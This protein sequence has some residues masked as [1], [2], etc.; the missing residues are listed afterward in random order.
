VASYFTDLLEK[1]PLDFAA[2][3]LWQFTDRPEAVKALFSA[4]NE[5][6]GILSDSSKRERLESLR[7]EDLENDR[8]YGEA[9]DV[10][11]RFRS[12]VRSIFLTPDNQI[13]KLTI[14]YG[15]F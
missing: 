13:G 9:R 2:E 1:T 15:V 6:L 12:A 11:H 7:P 14:E 8:V 4:Y 3:T 10:S 5:F